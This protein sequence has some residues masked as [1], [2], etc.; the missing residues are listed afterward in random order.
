MRAFRTGVPGAAIAS[1][2][3]DSLPTGSSCQPMDGERRSAKELLSD[4]SVFPSVAGVN[5][6]WTAMAL[7]H[8]CGN[9]L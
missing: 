7:A 8:L 3:R 2:D 5:P 1:E 6:Q 4:A 9:S